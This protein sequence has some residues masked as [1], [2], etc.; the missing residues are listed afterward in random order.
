[1]VLDGEVV[2]ASNPANSSP[3]SLLIEVP[4]DPDA[5]KDV[6]SALD[7]TGAQVRLLDGTD[8]LAVDRTIAPQPSDEG[9]G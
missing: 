2:A 9:C 5:E 6:F 4:P 3:D 8:V 1:M 7:I